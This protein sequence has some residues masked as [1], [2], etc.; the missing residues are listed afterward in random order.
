MS[1]I[2]VDPISVCTARLIMQFKNPSDINSVPI[3]LAVGTGFFRQYGQE[4]HLITNKHNVTGR[5]FETGEI[6]SKKGA[7]PNRIQ[8]DCFTKNL[9]ELSFGFNLYSGGNDPNDTNQKDRPLWLEHPDLDIVAL[10]FNNIDDFIYAE[11]FEMDAM[12]NIAQDVFVIGY[13]RGIDVGNLPIWKKATIASEIGFNAYNDQPSFL[14]DTATKEG[15][16]GSPVFAL[17]DGTYRDSLG[18]KILSSGKGRKFLG[19]YSGRLGD[20]V[21]EA[22]LG[23]VWKKEAIE[24]LFN[25]NQS[26]STPLKSEYTKMTGGNK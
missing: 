4:R 3:D 10:K 22:Q 13:P 6:L 15:M 8:V 14:I 1:R 12:V 23:I 24:K 17:I 9:K 16:S 11:D 21:F 19:I 7:I 18:N 20:N 26:N 5:H 25:E 2:E